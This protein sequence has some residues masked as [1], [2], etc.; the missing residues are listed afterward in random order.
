MFFPS[1][2]TSKCLC[3]S[4]MRTH[5]LLV[6]T[7]LSTLRFHE[8][9]Q[10]SRKPFRKSTLHHILV[11]KLFIWFCELLGAALLSDAD[12]RPPPPVNTDY[13]VSQGCNIYVSLQFYWLLFFENIHFFLPSSHFCHDKV[14]LTHPQ[15][16][17]FNQDCVPFWSIRV[18]M[19][20]LCLVC[21]SGTLNGTE[22]Y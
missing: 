4:G 6:L 9:T 2:S 16:G 13:I 19:L 3:M 18:Q 15:F 8:L 22:P 14:E 10:L 21:S 17:V 20:Y 11:I 7:Q 5:V 1:N 12:N